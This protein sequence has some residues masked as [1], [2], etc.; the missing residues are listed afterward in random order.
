MKVSIRIKQPNGT[1]DRMVFSANRT[2]SPVLEKQ[3]KNTIGD[4][5]KVID[6]VVDN[7]R[8]PMLKGDLGEIKQI[9]L[10]NYE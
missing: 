8:H 3:I 1:I 6:V 7:L 2:L 9:L 4:E 10:G 5:G